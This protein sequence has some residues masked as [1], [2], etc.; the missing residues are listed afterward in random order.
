MP[1]IRD[2]QKFR[3]PE[4]IWIICFQKTFKFRKI[5]TIPENLKKT[6][7]FEN[8]GV[9]LPRNQFFFSNWLIFDNV[10][11]HIDPK[12]QKHDYN[13]LVLIF[14]ENR[15][16]KRNKAQLFPW[17]KSIFQNFWNFEFSLVPSIIFIPCHGVHGHQWN[18][19]QI[20]V[21]HQSRHR[22][23]SILNLL[24]ML[25]IDQKC[26]FKHLRMETTDWFEWHATQSHI[27]A[28]F[29]SWV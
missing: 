11:I 16:L 6:F 9:N 1:K 22:A 10:Q 29:H 23:E 26:L 15:D 5:F 14:E 8:L 3:F 21:N 4:N 17:P 7:I 27:N 25:L 20:Q 18:R 12:L 2:S 19:P 24:P 28:D 13:N